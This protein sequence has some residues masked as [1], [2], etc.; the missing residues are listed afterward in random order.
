MRGLRQKNFFRGTGNFNR[1]SSE[2]RPKPQTLGVAAANSC[3]QP[4]RSDVRFRGQSGHDVLILS[5]SAFDPKR[6]LAGLQSRSA[7]VSSIPETFVS[8]Q[9]VAIYTRTAQVSRIVE[10]RQKGRQPLDL[11]ASGTFAQTIFR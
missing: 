10:R 2:P 1:G 9:L 6:T 3:T 5:F 7:A 8:S 11:V 4:R